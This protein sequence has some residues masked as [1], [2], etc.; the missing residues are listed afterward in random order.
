MNNKIGIYPGTFDP[1][2]I[3]HITFATESIHSCNL[4]KVLLLPEAQPRNK[5]HVSQLTLR[6]SHIKKSIADKPFLDIF[7]PKTASFTIQ[8]TLPEIQHAFK[9]NRLTFLIGSDVMKAMHT[10]PDIEMLLSQA[11]LAIGMRHTES[12]QEIEAI[13]QH[14]RQRHHS[15]SYTIVQTPH[16]EIS[17]TA[18]RAANSMAQLSP[19]K[20]DNPSTMAALAGHVIQK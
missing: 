14:I 20:F 3:G 18:I 2:H 4:D 13:I 17:S 16:A 9:N 12:R 10:W 19:D 11:H 6:S 5:P 7:H 15:L 1:L 8:E